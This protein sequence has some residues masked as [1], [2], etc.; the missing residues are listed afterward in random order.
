MAVRWRGTDSEGVLRVK[1]P[2]RKPYPFGDYLRGLRL[3][4]GLTQEALAERLGVAKFYYNKVETGKADPPSVDLLE[5]LARH[6]GADR[7]RLYAVAGKIPPE[8]ERIVR[9][10]PDLWPQLRKVGSQ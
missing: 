10:H 8:V 3:K 7:D 2:P 4:S 1:R 6:L 9:D 5:A